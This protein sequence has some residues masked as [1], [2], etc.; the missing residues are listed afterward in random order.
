MMS[1]GSSGSP[2][3]PVA[4]V[5]PVS[6]MPRS[7]VAIARDVREGRRTAVSVADEAIARIE[8]GDGAINS[9]VTRTFERARAE[10]A[11]IDARRA[12]GQALPALAGVPY[13]VKNLF[14]VDGVVTLAGGKVN[15]GNAA[16]THDATLVRRMR[17]AGAVLVGTLNMDE[18]AYGFTTE[19]THFGATRNPRDPSRSAGGSSGMGCGTGVGIPRTPDMSMW[20]FYLT[21]RESVNSGSWGTSLAIVRWTAR[22]QHALKCGLTQLEAP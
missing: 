1:P 7:A 19:N 12:S 2:G 14:D 20:V 21:M 6:P 9:F 10:A 18:H 15:A 16:A 17:D 3:V 11:A 22:S 13:A 4:P 5:L 8:S